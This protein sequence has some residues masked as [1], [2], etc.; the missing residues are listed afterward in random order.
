MIEAA[1]RRGV[2]LAEPLLEDV[3]SKSKGGIKTNVAKHGCA[4]IVELRL[5]G[6]TCSLVSGLHKTRLS[7]YTT[8][9]VPLQAKY[10]SR[11]ELRPRLS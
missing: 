1:S 9:R 8:E 5:T 2:R 11:A 10:H 6:N 3:A 4:N 7:A